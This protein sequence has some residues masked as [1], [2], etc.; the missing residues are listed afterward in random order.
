MGRLA[1]GREGRS[2]RRLAWSAAHVT[3]EE[4]ESGQC[5][6]P[7]L[8]SFG[9]IVEDVEVQLP[10]VFDL[11][12]PSS[13]SGGELGHGGLGLEL[14]GKK[15]REEEEQVKGWGMGRA[16]RPRSRAEKSRS[17]GTTA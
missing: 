5:T 12:G 7:W 1:E 4:R 2:R 16:G 8:D 17:G 9:E 10:M 6:T 3:D 14:V 15:E 13:I 11:L